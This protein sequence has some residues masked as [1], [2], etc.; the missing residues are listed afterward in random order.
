MSVK[1][2]AVICIILT[3]LLFPPAVY[4]QS[5]NYDIWGDAVP[6]QA[7]YTAVESVSGN[8]LGISDFSSPSDLFRTSDG[9]L[10]IADS[11]NNRIIKTDESLSEVLAVIDK[12]SFSGNISALS[13]PKGIYFSPY[14]SR[15]Y[16]ADTDNSRVIRCSENGIADLIIE[17]PDTDENTGFFPEK[18]IADKSG[19]IYVITGNTSNG[20]MMFD[21]N[22]SFTGYYGANRTEPTLKVIKN[23][24]YNL[25]RTYSISSSNIRNV[26]SAFTGF[27][28]DN[29]E[30]IFTCTE[31]SATDVIKKINS[32]GDNLFYYNKNRFGDHTEYYDA[33][34][35]AIVDIDISEGGY[36]NCLD[37][38]SCRIFQYD[39]KLRLVSVS[40]GKSEAL[41]G[42]RNVSALESSDDF[43]YVADPDKNTITVFKI[44]EFGKTVHTALEAGSTGDY[45]K[46]LP[47]WSDTLKYDCNY[48]IACEEISAAMFYKGDYHSAMQYAKQCFSSKLYNRAFERYRAEFITGHSSAIYIPMLMLILLSA[49]A[50]KIRKPEK[51][52]Y[53]MN[54]MNY[55]QWCIYAVKHPFESFSDIIWKK[56]TSFR[57]TAAV[58]ILL[59]ISE[60]FS[61][62]LYGIQFHFEYSRTFSIIPYIFR[63]AGLFFIWTTANWS[64]C[65]LLDGKGTFRNICAVSAYSLMPYIIHNFIN[66]ILSHILTYDEKFFLTVISAAGIAWSAIMMISALKSVHQYTLKKT[67]CSLILTFTAMIVIMMLII[68]MLTA[69]DRICSFVYSLITETI[70]RIKT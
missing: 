18:V 13:N 30:F 12:I 50:L 31:G 68:L 46:A 17:N 16:I 21:E 26:P 69:A 5:Y 58:I 61:E 15:L 33:D 38:T 6:S 9:D 65:C 11:G 3:M 60:I 25:F 36:I 20:A 8:S 44:S 70:Y 41:G 64:V 22:G 2:P 19:C 40:G 1:I 24:F 59:F 14:D 54:E 10:F 57:F 52:S 55:F 45:E 43:L 34:D 66:V 28:I 63:S 47:L 48:Y 42:F 62:R 35:L 56:K 7:G 39:E 51:I 23:Y 53:Q 37:R 32:A 67:V 29:E 27:D 49:Y 4:A